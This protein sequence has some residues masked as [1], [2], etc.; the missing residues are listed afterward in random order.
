M[1]AYRLSEV[2]LGAFPCSLFCVKASQASG[3][4]LNLT[5]I[6]CKSRNSAIFRERQIMRK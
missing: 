6:C 1:A 4:V 3:T 2:D 5:K